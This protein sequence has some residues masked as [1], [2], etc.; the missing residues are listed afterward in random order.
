MSR[1]PP[2]MQG[3]SLVPILKGAAPGDWRR[4]FY[5]H[6]YESQLAHGVPAHEGVRTERYKLI[7]FYE[8]GEW[9]LFDLERDPQELQSLYGRKGMEQV[10]AELQAELKRLRAHYGVSEPPL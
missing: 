10:T 9:E 6:Y 8:S 7:R 1:I 5:Y 3:R 4:S 2:R